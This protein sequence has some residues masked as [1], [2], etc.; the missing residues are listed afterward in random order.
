MREFKKGVKNIFQKLVKLL[1]EIFGFGDEVVDSALTSAEK[2]VKDNKNAQTRRLAER[3]G[4]ISPEL[5]TLLKDKSFSEIYWDLSNG[6]IKRVFGNLLKYEEEAVL[7]FYTTNAGYKNFNKA[8]RGE[9]K[10]TGFYSTQEKLMNEALEKLPV[11]ESENLLYRIENLTEVQVKEYYKVG[12]VITNRHFTS[13]T[14]SEEAVEGAIELR[15]AN[16][17]IRI[18]N[19]NGRLIENLSTLKKEK[20][21]LFKSSTKFYVKEIG[22]EPNPYEPWV[23][24]KRIILVEK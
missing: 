11:Y 17:L 10:M 9:I 7:R 2:R 20:E 3:L 6:K 14:Y 16:L 12:E 22:F 13:A 1:N 19:K 21:V 8:L 15:P 18:E 4:L 24:M 23:P 5:K